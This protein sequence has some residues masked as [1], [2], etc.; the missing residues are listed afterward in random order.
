MKKYLAPMEGLTGHVFRATYHNHFK[1]FDRYFTPF[2]AT[3]DRL[4]FKTKKEIDREI[5]KDMEL[6]VQL[7]TNSVEDTL[8]LYK[9]IKEYGYDHINI[10]LGCPSGTV[11]SKKRGSG[12]L[13]VLDEMEK[14]FDGLFDLPDV[15]ISVKTRI[16]V[17]SIDEW[18]KI[19]EVYKKFP[20]EELI[21]HPRLRE[22]Q[23]NGKPNLDA[24]NY[25]FNE[26]TC[27]LVYNGDVYTVE[28]YYNIQAKFPTIRGIMLGRGILR[29]PFLL[30]DIEKAE[31][32]EMLEALS[33]SI[34]A[35]EIKEAKEVL[36]CSSSA[37]NPEKNEESRLKRLSGYIRDLEAY[38]AK[39]MPSEKALLYRMKE[40]WLYLSNYFDNKEKVTKEIK[41]C[42]SIS[43]YHRLLLTLGL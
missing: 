38:Y 10:N 21:I 2:I 7:M 4:N 32:T 3:N 17:K 14:F 9:E 8:V 29:N 27:P 39:E 16:G 34:E 43:D 42:Q 26:L 37:E 40:N 19:V 35:K 20:F 12:F 25:A 36:D 1:D 24:F 11:V 23:Y 31:K 28:D 41:K 13:S 5:N 15:K 33:K 30:E 6:V 18:P 22:E